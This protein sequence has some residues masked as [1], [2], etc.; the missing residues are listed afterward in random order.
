VVAT[1]HRADPAYAPAAHQGERFTR[2]FVSGQ[3]TVR[4]IHAVSRR[5]AGHPLKPRME[6]R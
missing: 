4:L 1:R 5:P 3:I 6:E 2:L